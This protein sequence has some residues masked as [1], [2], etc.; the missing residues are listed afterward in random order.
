MYQ[1][2]HPDQH[3][4]YNLLKLKAKGRQ[5]KAGGCHCLKSRCQARYCDCFARGGGVYGGVQVPAVPEH[6]GELAGE[7]AEGEEGGG[8]PVLQERLPEELLRVL[9]EGRV[10]H[11]QVQ[12]H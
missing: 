1:H 11:Q 12:V 3:T 2:P 6:G 7:E 5:H 8:V 9:P 4:I 10:L